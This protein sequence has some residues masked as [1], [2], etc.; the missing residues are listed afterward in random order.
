VIYRDL[1]LSHTFFTFLTL[2]SFLS[3]YFVDA[4]R[5]FRCKLNWH[6]E[7]PRRIDDLHSPIDTAPV[8]YGLYA[9]YVIH[10]AGLCT[11]SGGILLLPTL[12]PPSG[13]DTTCSSSCCDNR[14]LFL[15]LRSAVA[16]VY[17]IEDNIF[18]IFK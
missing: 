6:I 7:L 12:I 9:L 8:G 3:C 11:S 13:V 2:L 17:V 1:C 14:Q 16:K 15:R 5:L 10:K 18:V 4:L